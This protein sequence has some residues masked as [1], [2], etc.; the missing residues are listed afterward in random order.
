[1]DLGGSGHTGAVG[2]AVEEAVRLYTVAD[3]PNAAVLAGRSERVDGTLEA[4]EVVRIS[5]GH[6]HLERLG[7]P[8]T[9][10][11]RA[12]PHGGTHALELRIS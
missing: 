3:N 6:R 1:M 12:H 8:R 9:A 5:P 4:V 2:A 7:V 11:K 10:H